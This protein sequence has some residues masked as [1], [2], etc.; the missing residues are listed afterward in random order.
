MRDKR[1]RTL[2]Y[3]AAN[4]LLTDCGAWIGLEFEVG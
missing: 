2:L 4:V 1:V 3:E